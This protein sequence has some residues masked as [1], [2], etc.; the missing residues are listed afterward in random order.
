LVID[1]VNIN[2]A[3]NYRP[4]N[5]GKRHLVKAVSAVVGDGK[6]Q[7]LS[8]VF[9]RNKQWAAAGMDVLI[10][11]RNIKVISL[12]LVPIRHIVLSILVPVA[13]RKVKNANHRGIIG[14]RLR[15]RHNIF[16]LV[17]KRKS[18]RRIFLHRCV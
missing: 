15:Q 4:K 16:C 7:E 11:E 12:V 10:T 13:A 17:G 9:F 6:T 8:S 5:Y 2:K 14:K 3:R 1:I 18:C